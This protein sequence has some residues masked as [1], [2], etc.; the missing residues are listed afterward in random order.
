MTLV[1]LSGVIET[2]QATY[3]EYT[4]RTPH[5]IGPIQSLNFKQ[6]HRTYEIES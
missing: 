4:H 6:D 3:E 1:P 5:F 2:E